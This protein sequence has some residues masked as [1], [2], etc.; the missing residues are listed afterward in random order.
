M[1][2]I[3]TA[4]AK[5]GFNAQQHLRDVFTTR[6]DNTKISRG[7]TIC[8]PPTAVR[9]THI[10]GVATWRMLP[11]RLRCHAKYVVDASYLALRDI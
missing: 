8:P 4:N 2:R 9:R 6:D 7:E 5:H 10:D 3:L 1:T 11:Q